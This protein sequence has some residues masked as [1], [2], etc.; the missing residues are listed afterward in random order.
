MFIVGS[1]IWVK[2]YVDLNV[3]ILDKPLIGGLIF[4]VGLLLM[5]DGAIAIA[6]LRA[7]SI[8]SVP[9]LGI[10][11]FIVI[12]VTTLVALYI[13]WISYLIRK[14][15]IKEPLMIVAVVFAGLV[16]LLVQTKAFYYIY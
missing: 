14:G 16:L 15:G 13:Y 10:S 12:M 3:E 8:I 4:A 1:C 2:K 9:G 7:W 6:V 5:V 11:W